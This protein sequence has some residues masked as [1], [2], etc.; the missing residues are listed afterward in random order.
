MDKIKSVNN[1]NKLNITFIFHVE[2]CRISL[3]K[4]FAMNMSIHHEWNVLSLESTLLVNFN[5]FS[6]HV[7]AI[8]FI[9]YNS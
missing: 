5:V 3:T 2:N 9:W 8:I 7:A 6:K 1:E 4:R